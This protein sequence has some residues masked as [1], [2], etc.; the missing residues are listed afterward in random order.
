M[1]ATKNYL[2]DYT[3]ALDETWIAL[4]AAICKF[5]ALNDL[6]YNEQGEIRSRAPRADV[7]LLAN[8]VKE[9]TG[10][11]TCYDAAKE[12]SMLSPILPGEVRYAV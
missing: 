1:S 8:K 4:E 5:K 3:E 10:E 7:R 2:Q 6:V 11:M 12:P 9:L